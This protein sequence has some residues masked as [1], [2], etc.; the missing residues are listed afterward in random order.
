MGDGVLSVN[1]I[2]KIL[3]ESF[4]RPLRLDEAGVKLWDKQVGRQVVEKQNTQ[5]WK[6]CGKT[7]RFPQ[8]EEKF[9]TTRK[10]FSP[11]LHLL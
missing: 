5:K 9:L 8:V 7:S 6:E 4:I 11:M 2:V 1:H 3:I 10:V